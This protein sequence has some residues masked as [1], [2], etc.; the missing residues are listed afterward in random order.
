RLRCLPGRCARDRHRRAATAAGIRAWRPCR[1]RPAH[2]A[3]VVS[4][5]PAKHEHRQA[6]AADVRS[7]LRAGARPLVMRWLRQPDGPAERIGGKAAGLGRAR[8]AGARVPDGFAID[9]AAYDAA[10]RA[11][12][13]PWTVDEADPLPA[14]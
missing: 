2:A 10:V 5:E 6:D 7:H 13:G 14:L 12:G 11:A 4:P 8:A 3:G 9:A 1:A